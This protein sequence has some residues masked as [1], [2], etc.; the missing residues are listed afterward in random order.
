M[1]TPQDTPQSEEAKHVLI[2][3]RA[4]RLRNTVNSEGWPD[5]I[6]ISKAIV[7]GALAEVDGYTGTD[8]HKMAQLT[9]I[10]KTVKA[11]HNMLIGTI[12][13]QIED[14]DASNNYLQSLKNPQAMQETEESVTGT[15]VIPLCDVPEEKP[16]AERE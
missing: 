7:D 10:W 14:G 12:Q 6:K 9:F 15:A 13:K 1:K 4:I 11:H 2:I 16:H 8:D 5:F 3:N